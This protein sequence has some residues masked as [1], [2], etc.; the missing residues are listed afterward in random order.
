MNLKLALSSELL[1]LFL[2]FMAG[3]GWKKYFEIQL[4]SEIFTSKKHK[5]EKKQREKILKIRFKPVVRCYSESIVT[6]LTGWAACVIHYNAW[7][8]CVTS[9][10]GYQ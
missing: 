1:D 5:M 9:N 10:V 6:T 3:K 8:A 2:N 7:A 4:Y